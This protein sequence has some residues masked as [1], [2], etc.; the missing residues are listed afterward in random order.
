MAGSN[1]L[2]R[3]KLEKLTNGQL[4][5]FAMKPQGNLISKQTEL[6]NDNKELWEKFNVIEAKFEDLIKENEIL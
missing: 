5:D 3:K 2:T 1:I 6:T 4:I